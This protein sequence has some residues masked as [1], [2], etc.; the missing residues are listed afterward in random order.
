MSRL[1]L[2]HVIPLLLLA[3]ACGGGGAGQQTAQDQLPEITLDGMRDD[4]DGRWVKVPAADGKSRPLDPWVFDHREPKEIKILEQKIEGENATFLIDI[5][6]RSA[7][8]SKN[9]YSLSGQLRVHYHLDSGL[10]LREWRI[11]GIDNISF[12]YVNEQPTPEEDSDASE[13]NANGKPKA[14]ANS[15]ANAKPK[16]GATPQSN[17]NSSRTGGDR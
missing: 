4:L 1:R 8:K 6:T 3:C 7:P 14:D 10:V 2:A 9:H 12:K 17:A 16:A 5:N 13:G 11:D 15:N